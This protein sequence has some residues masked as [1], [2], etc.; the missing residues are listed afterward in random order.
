I[1]YAAVYAGFAFSHA[2]WQVW[3]LFA[4]YGLYAGLVEGAERALVADLA[5]ADARGTAFGWYNLA[6][7]IGALPASVI[8]GILW[9]L[10]G[11]AAALGFGAVMALL[12]AAALAAGGGF[13]RAD[14]QAG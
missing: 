6:V 14:R 5:P 12:A 13:K 7:G 2:A 1:T 8:A 10:S 3:A 4:T 11:P 9:K